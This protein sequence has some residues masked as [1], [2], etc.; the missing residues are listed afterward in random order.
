MNKI[1]LLFP[2]QGSQ[3]IG[4][5]KKICD[6]YKVA[7][8]IFC[9]A[10]DILGWDIQKLCYEGN[11]EELTKTYNAQLSILTTS[12]A[13]YKVYMEE[14]GVR[15]EMMA[16]HSLGEISALT[17]AGAIEFKDALKLV[18]KRGQLMHESAM[19]TE[20]AM[21][22]I[23]GVEKEKI[24]EQFV[25]LG[26]KE[27]VIANHNSKN[28]VVISGFRESIE[29]VLNHFNLL[30][31]KFIQLNVSGA[32]HS[33]LMQKAA[34][35]FK[36][37]IKKYNFK[38]LQCPVISN[39]NAQPYVSSK[40]ITEIL[41]KQIVSTVCWHESM[42][43]LLNNN[44]DTC[45][46]IGVG[47]VLTK[48]LKGNKL[49]RVFAL[50]SQT[51]IC[52][53]KQ[54]VAEAKLEISVDESSFINNKNENEEN[55][56]KLE[57]KLNNSY[58]EIER[59][60]AKVYQEILGVNE[61]N[62]YDSFYELGGDSISMMKIVLKLKENYGYEISLS[63]FVENISIYNISRCIE[64]ADKISDPIIY[65]NKEMDLSKIHEP[66]S[67]TDIQ[68]AY[69]TG[70]DNDFVMGGVGT[71]VYL[72][73]SSKLDLN[74][75]NN[76]ICKVIDRH[77]GLRSVF[78][79]DGRQRILKDVPKFEMEVVDISDLSLQQQKSKIE[80]ERSKLSHRVFDAFSWPI[81]GFKAF[82]VSENESYL[83]VD[84]DMLIIDGSSLQIM[85]KEIM[86]FYNNQSAIIPEIEFTFS[87]YMDA[88]KEI[89]SSKMYEDDKKYW[90]EK[91]DDFPSAPQ[92]PIINK[93]ENI[94]KPKFNRF[95][96]IIPIELL[97]KIKEKVNKNNL[98]L[99]SVLCTAYMEVLAYWSNQEK[100]SINLTVFN[101]YPVNKDVEKII[102]DFT[103]TVILGVENEGKFDFWEK[104]KNVQGIMME[105]LE[106]R[107]YDGVE[108]IREIAKRSN[109]RNNVLMP[110]VFTSM[111][112]NGD[113]MEGLFEL[114]ELKFSLSQTPQVFIDCQVLEV[115][116]EL[117]LTWDY[118]EQLFE[119][120]VI[121]TM[122]SQFVQIVMGIIDDSC[123]TFHFEPTEEDLELINKYNDTGNESISRTLHGM[124]VEKAKVVP[125][126]IAIEMDEQ[127]VTYSELD[128]MSNKVASYLTELG[129]K[130]G[131][132]VAVITERCCNTIV[133]IMGVLKAGAAY[134]PI[135]PT[136]PED[137]K[138]HI[139]ENSNCTLV[140]EP[141]LFIEKQLDK[142]TNVELCCNNPN[143]VAYVIYTSGSTGTPKGVVISHFAACNTIC[144]VNSMFEVGENDRILGISSMCFD[145]SIYDIFG[146]LSAGATLVMISDQRDVSLLVDAVYKKNITVWNSVP[147]IMGMMIDNLDD[148]EELNE[149]ISYRK[150]DI[151][152][153]RTNSSD[154]YFW[155]PIVQ[156][157]IENDNLLINGMKYGNNISAIFPRFYFRAQKGIT[158]EEAIREF[159]DINTSLLEE[160]WKKLIDNKV[161]TNHIL[162]AKDIFKSQEKLFVNEYGEDLAFNLEALK[163][164]KR[165][166]YSRII[167]NDLENKIILE[168][169]KDFISYL[170]NRKSHRDFNINDKITFKQISNILSTFKQRYFG[171]EVKYHYASAGGLYPIDIFIYIKKNR[172]EGINPGIYYYLPTDNSIT[173]V[174]AGEVISEEAHY[175]TNKQ[176]F[177]SSA[178]SI[179]FIYNAEV[180]MPKYGTDGYLYAFLDTGIMAS[181]VNMVAERYGIGMCSIGDMVF[182]KVRKFFRLNQNQVLIHTIEGGIK[183]E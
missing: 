40:Q 60:I 95:Q 159:K 24:E 59:N 162:D 17:C 183:N 15:P 153:N 138:Q 13:M 164:F 151:V 19:E 128:E 86:Y 111:L 96:K 82:K 50:D 171:N 36:D 48:L 124:F 120:S 81:F 182:S 122:F 53:L 174:K 106:H 178:F 115:N 57:G 149:V 132:F 152:R 66:F 42:E 23:L 43:Y 74:R 9:E 125:N 173:L 176:I 118:V 90:L 58:T 10:N 88:Y 98:S 41:P 87:D 145:L 148:T 177:N 75:L 38:E 100:L 77:P 117:M 133:N 89:K 163:D 156:W 180:N 147:A 103:S 119:Q 160:L 91:I 47:N 64:I 69:L 168:D 93:P 55:F 76:S 150:K 105:G 141:N 20:G 2:G 108:F 46:E 25:K 167:V 5:G 3:Y 158:L 30:G 94:G 33:P 68:L 65:S 142:Y 131:D 136:Y 137:R 31:W 35:Q 70:R 179:Y 127:S 22:A 130:Q 62:V 181:T 143:D 14:I 28:Q 157:S 107:H 85:G 21:V 6:T 27:I 121:T 80:N 18:R 44:I 110:I 135:D 165:K 99:S 29:R 61:I 97:N 169:N 4:M 140:M 161:L 139:F 104:A 71:H 129:I 166:Q 175:F 63:K 49:I 84:F 73:F 52:S 92:L 1:A 172:V 116:G 102:G 56:V 67:I 54:H 101:R 134:I 170:N 123:T 113:S 79:P 155:S 34:E 112:H 146:A 72:E 8:D 114:G 12:V 37:E 126:N 83:F 11:I 26:V 16:G 109:Q 32:F 154:V 144:D 39:F 7:K 51:D 45:I 78:L